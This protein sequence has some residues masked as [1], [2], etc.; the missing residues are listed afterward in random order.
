MNLEKENDVKFG[1]ERLKANVKLSCLLLATIGLG[2]YQL[3]KEKP[4][5]KKSLLRGLNLAISGLNVVLAAACF[6]L[7]AVRYGLFGKEK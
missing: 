5:Q 7:T 1:N 3:K 4:M 2:I 6:G